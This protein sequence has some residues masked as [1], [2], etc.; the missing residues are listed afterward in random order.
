MS[1]TYY[2]ILHSKCILLTL[3]D[4]INAQ[5]L[6]QITHGIPP[7]GFHKPSLRNHFG[8]WSSNLYLY[9]SVYSSMNLFIIYLFFRPFQHAST[10][11]IS[12]FQAIQYASTLHISMFQAIPA[13]IYSSYLY[14]SGHS[15]MHLL[16]ISLC[17]R[18]FQHASTPCLLA[19][20]LTDTAEKFWSSGSNVIKHFF[21]VIYV[22]L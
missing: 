3:K 20:G 11:H 4:G 8:L 14:V 22:F 18:P 7:I 17:F 9:V 2:A 19:P 1:C 15:S 10:V 5:N 13:C 12:M 6:A 16:F 21:S